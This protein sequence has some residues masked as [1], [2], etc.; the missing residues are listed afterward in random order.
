MQQRTTPFPDAAR[1]LRLAALG[2]AL[3]VVLA[4]GI[5][6]CQSVAPDDTLRVRITLS[7]DSRRKLT[8]RFLR[9]RDDRLVI[10]KR[11]GEVTRVAIGNVARVQVSAGRARRPLKGAA[12]FGFIGAGMGLIRT[13]YADSPEERVQAQ[14][15]ATDCQLRTPG[16][17]IC[18]YAAVRHVSLSPA[19]AAVGALVGAAIGGV[20]GTVIRTDSWR[21][22]TV[23]MLIERAARP[24]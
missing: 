18:N 10:E 16:A 4:A 7:G 2:A 15:Q 11:S 21:P 9:I 20:I 13:E 5:A 12:A 22:A 17:Q 1:V 24:R 23:D 3:H 19:G 6:D 8:G 14:Q